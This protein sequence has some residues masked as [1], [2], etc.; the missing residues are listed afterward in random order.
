MAICPRLVVANYVN[1]VLFNLGISSKSL[2]TTS[3]FSWS[4]SPLISLKFVW[5]SLYNSIPKGGYT[6]L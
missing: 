3:F 4:E 1:N 2:T 6:L 5:K